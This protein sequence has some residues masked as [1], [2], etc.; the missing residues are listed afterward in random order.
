MNEKGNIYIQETG[1]TE[2]KVT[3]IYFFFFKVYFFCDVIKIFTSYYTSYNTIY[4][5]YTYNT[6]AA[7]SMFN[8]VKMGGKYQGVLLLSKQLKG[9]HIRPGAKKD[10]REGGGVNIPNLKLLNNNKK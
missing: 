7:A 6:E 9:R 4:K 8:S 2:I 1:L 10:L 3:P 5:A